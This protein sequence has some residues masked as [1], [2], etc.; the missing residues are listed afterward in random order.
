MFSS[1]GNQLEL[2]VLGLQNPQVNQ[3]KEKEGIKRRKKE[4]A[5]HDL[6]LLLLLQAILKVG[7]GGKKPGCEVLC[8]RLLG[9]CA[10]Q[11]LNHGA[12][13]LAIS[14]S[15]IEEPEIGQQSG[16]SELEGLEVWERLLEGEFKDLG[17]VEG[18]N[19]PVQLPEG[20]WVV[21]GS[22]DQ[23]D[24]SLEFPSLIAL[25]G[26]SGKQV[27]SAHTHPR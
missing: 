11:A 13:C 6:H 21:R 27:A 25:W 14:V 18:F 2:D 22:P 1:F 23:D 7:V 9:F 5:V 17:A 20:P 4:R 10:L 8:L 3:E 15:L 12:D 16:I 24:P 19:V 26:H